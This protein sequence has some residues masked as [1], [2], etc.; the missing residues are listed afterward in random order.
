VEET[1]SESHAPAVRCFRRFLLIGAAILLPLA[2]C[3]DVPGELSGTDPEFAQGP[4]HGTFYGA[5]TPLGEGRVRTYIVVRDGV[6]TELGIAL[7]EGALSGLPEGHAGDGPHSGHIVYLLPM[8]PQNPTPYQFAE[9]DWNPH[10][11]EPAQIYGVPHFDFHFYTISRAEREAIDPADPRF[12]ENARHL[13]PAEYVPQ[14]YLDVATILG[15]PAEAVAM[16]Q[17]GL[18]WVDPM[19]PELHGAPFTHSFFFGSWAGRLI[20][21]E[22]MVSLAFL[23]TKPDVT[24]PIAQPQKFS[25]AGFYPGSYRV[26]WDAQRK[27]IR[28]ALTDFQ[29][30]L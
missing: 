6:P 18:H 16:P 19:T 7:S 1:M 23:A 8:H 28:V 25:P 4:D 30:K 12:V 3:S 2:G 22:P 26:Y 21:G 11:H 17:M 27:E 10:G 9:L 13:P 29:A 5:A 24:A 14:G 15:A 20:F